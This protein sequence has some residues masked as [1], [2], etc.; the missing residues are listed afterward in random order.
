[1][2]GEGCSCGGVLGELRGRTGGK[3]T[4]LHSRDLGRDCKGCLFHSSLN[5]NKLHL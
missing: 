2:S 5:S 3:C 1:M 4:G